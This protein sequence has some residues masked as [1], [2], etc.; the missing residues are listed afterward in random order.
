M[1][2]AVSNVTS[3]VWSLVISMLA[4]Y[5]AVFNKYLLRNNSWRLI[6]KKRKHQHRENGIVDDDTFRRIV[7]RYL[8]IR[9]Y[10]DQQ[11]RC[12]CLGDHTTRNIRCPGPR[13]FGAS[14]SPVA[15]RPATRTQRRA[16]TR[17]HTARLPCPRGV[18]KDRVIRWT[19]KGGAATGAARHRCDV[20]TT[21]STAAVNRTPWTGTWTS[22]W[23][24]SSGTTNS[25][26]CTGTCPRATGL[27]TGTIRRGGQRLL[28][29]PTG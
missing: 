1:S 3:R 5:V 11:S 24:S 2:V 28:R 20:V 29:S 16:G 22:T 18:V 23:S 6:K 10:Q 14:S 25:P 27:G 7:Y 13:I 26:G 21:L 17:Y 8:R 9:T 12:G 15:S 19:P 4:Q